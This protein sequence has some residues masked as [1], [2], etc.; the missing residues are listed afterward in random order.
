MG[1]GRRTGPLPWERQRATVLR[2]SASQ[3]S[4]GVLCPGSQAQGLATSS[5]S[6]VARLALRRPCM[7]S[8]ATPSLQLTLRWWGQFWRLLTSSWTATSRGCRHGHRRAPLQ[9]CTWV[10][11]VLLTAG[12]GNL[13]GDRPHCARTGTWRGC[14]TCRPVTGTRFGQAPLSCAC[15]WTSPTWS[16]S[17]AAS[18]PWR[19]RPL[20]CSG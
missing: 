12:P 1:R 18:S 2:L 3:R 15:R 4:A 11:R 13:T 10:L 19:T 8:A 17:R 6:S 20:R 5:R 9:A 7:R 14:P 16:C